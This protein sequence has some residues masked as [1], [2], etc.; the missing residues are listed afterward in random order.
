MGTPFG[1]VVVAGSRYVLYL[2]VIGYV[3]GM[4]EA[5]L[6]AFVGSLPIHCMH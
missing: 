4:R 6:C 5:V 3:L 1:L 2:W